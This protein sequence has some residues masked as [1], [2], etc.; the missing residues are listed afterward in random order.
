MSIA[1]R[2]LLAG[3]FGLVALFVFWYLHEGWPTVAWFA[4]IPLLLAAFNWTGRQKPAFW[5]GLCALGWFSHGVM[6][7]WSHA[8]QRQLA[9]IEIALA[10]VV[11]VGA[12]LP[13]LQARFGGR[14]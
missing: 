10:L 11:F 8:E 7:A 3:L 1:T 14:R 6:V 2:V 12:T 4:G 5:A 9:L 13:G